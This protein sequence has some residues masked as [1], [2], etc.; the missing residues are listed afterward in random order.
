MFDARYGRS[1]NQFFKTYADPPGKAMFDAEKAGL[2]A[3]KVSFPRIPAVIGTGSQRG[4]AYLLLEW[5]EP[6]PPRPDRWVRLG[7]DLARLHQQ[8]APGFGFPI[9]NFVG[10]LPQDN[11]L[12]KDWNS[13][14]FSRRILPLINRGVALGLFNINALEQI[15][16]LSDRFPPEPPSLLHGDLWYGNILPGP[17]GQF[18]L[19]DPSAYWGH[20]EM[21]LAMTRLFGGFPPSFYEAYQHVY[22]LQPGWEERLGLC[23]LYPL[24]VHALLFG[25]GYIEDAM[26][27]VRSYA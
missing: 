27:V 26:A 10:T 2:E 17:D 24:L 11:T 13:F 21:D 15:K 5:V 1:G 18:W 6:S 25:G 16:G 3:L 23:Q 20:R 22:P 8:P 4:K 9:P 7:E 12:E 14:Y 19:C